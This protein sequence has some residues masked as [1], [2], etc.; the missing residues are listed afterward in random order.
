MNPESISQ[1]IR[2]SQIDNVPEYLES[3]PCK[4]TNLHHLVKK[5]IDET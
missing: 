2:N 4:G 1:A 3:I 5:I